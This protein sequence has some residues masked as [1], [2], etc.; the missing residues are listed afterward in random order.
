MSAPFLIEYVDRRDGLRK[1]DSVASARFLRWAYNTRSGRWAEHAIFATKRFSRFYGWLHRRRWSRRK[2]VPFVREMGIDRT[3]INRPLEDFASFHDFFIRD[4]DLARRPFA[5]GPEICTAPVD[6]RILAFTGLAPDRSFPVK[7]AV[8]DLRGF[9]RDDG[10]ADRFA[11]GTLVICRLGLADYHYV[12]FPFSGVP[13]QP[14]PIPGK[15]HAGG[16]YALRRFIPF[17]AENFRMITLID[18]ERFGRA[19]MVEIGVLGVGSIVQLFSPHSPAAKGAKKARFELG[20]STVALLFEQGRL[21]VDPD[22]LAHTAEGIET[23]VRLGES[24]GR[25]PDSKSRAQE[26]A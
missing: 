23:Y 26:P 5:A 7:R 12:H 19:A 17:Y 15:Y 1:A 22:L 13:E 16:P 4:I 21:E 14:R 3:E 11:G 9:L 18:S 20:G 10:L 2:I 25:S 8:F 6:G 24:I